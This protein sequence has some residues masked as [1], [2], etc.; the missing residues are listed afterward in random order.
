M[1]KRTAVWLMIA[2]VLVLAGCILFAGVMTELKWDFKSLS[3]VQ[4]ETKTHTVTD[5]FDAVSVTA[6]T[7]DI[8]FAPAADDTVSVVCR[9][10]SS[11]RHSVSVENN[12]LTIK[13]EDTRKW[14]EHIG[15]QFGSSAITVYLPEGSYGA[16]TITGSTGDV[17]VPIDFTFASMDVRVST[18]DVS[19]FASTLGSKNIRT[20][21][22]DILLK[23]LDAGSLALSATTGEISV[24][25]VGTGELTV[26]V[27]TG[28]VAMSGIR[29][30]H[31][32]ATGSTGD[33]FLRDVL[34]T[35][36]FSIR[37]STGDVTF[38]DCDAA[39]LTVTTDTGDIKGT[40]LTAKVFVTHTDTGRVD[41]PKTAV[42]GKC[43]LTTD[44]GDVN[45]TIS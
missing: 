11:M 21:T 12:T 20:T 17:Y 4:F 31:L 28:D 10:T 27:S 18:G 29:C 30:N 2:A 23:G 39:S 36:T 22:G 9:E 45:I 41:V 26:S 19:S 14:Y 16:L 5:A 13:L 6:D 35:Q 38:E 24:K 8:T 33:V 25:N 37:R 3:T 42:G 1:S 43:E 32:T 34:A 44:T 7:A 40:L 15:I